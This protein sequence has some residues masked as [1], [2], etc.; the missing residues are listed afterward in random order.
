LDN[1]SNEQD[2]TTT[3]KKGSTT[4]KPPSLEDSKKKQVDTLPDVQPQTVLT[5]LLQ[6]VPCD[7]SVLR[8]EPFSSLDPILATRIKAALQ[9]MQEAVQ[10]H[11]SL[12]R[13][14]FGLPATTNSIPIAVDMFESK[15]AAKSKNQKPPPKKGGKEEEIT[16]SEEEM[17]K[18]YDEHIAE[19]PPLLLYRLYLTA[20]TYD[21]RDICSELQDIVIK[22]LDGTRPTF[23]VSEG[24]IQD[25][26]GT[27]PQKSLI[28]IIGLF[29]SI[30]SGDTTVD[31]MA[32][33]TIMATLLNKLKNSTDTEV[34]TIL[35]DAVLKSY[36]MFKQYCS[37][38]DISVQIDMLVSLFSASSETWIK[39]VPKV[40]DM[41]IRLAL[42]YESIENYT[43]ALAVLS[44]SI[45]HV[46]LRRELI[47]ASSEV[48]KDV[49]MTTKGS[50]EQM[51]YCIHTEILTHIL[52]IDMVSKI[53]HHNLI[54]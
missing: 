18:M 1:F 2:L 51:L 21:Q 28:Q 13:K 44:D 17:I 26:T 9:N 52:R 10:P 14:G 33:L 34:R 31:K 22:L 37:S 54:L 5:Y 48:K 8:H 45:D 24:G 50:T 7:D 29:T 19:T 25:E 49:S 12:Y 6:S 3:G 23:Q 20:Y 39:D 35:S 41:A 30:E 47:V 27:S 40:A 53:L 4:N 15:L 43:S 16:L 11:I 32:S 46:H 42:L 38:A 36:D